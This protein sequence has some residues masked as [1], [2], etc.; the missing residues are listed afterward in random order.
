MTS[1]PVESRSSTPEGSRRFRVRIPEDSPFFAGHFPDDPVLPAVAQ[2]ALQV[3]LLE[4]V[5]GPRARLAGVRVVRFRA[6][7]GPG[8][9][10]DVVLDGEG[11]G[12][13]GVTAQREGTVVLEGRLRLA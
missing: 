1:F 6:P 2:F 9:V 13:V 4:E 12:E 7:V 5:F 8:D 10:L 11:D 3:Q